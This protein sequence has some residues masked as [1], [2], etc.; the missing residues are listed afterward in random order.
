MVI[1]SSNI[2]LAS[3]P[4][5][6]RQ[7]VRFFNTSGDFCAPT[8][9]INYKKI[10]LYMGNNFLGTFARI[11]TLI[12]DENARL[13][14]HYDFFERRSVYLFRIRIFCYRPRHLSIIRQEPEKPGH[15][16]FSALVSGETCSLIHRSIRPHLCS[17]GHFSVRR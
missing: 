1:R 2:R 15:S 14:A 17:C 4:F 10:F 6:Y 9:P 5:P 13:Y 3:A 16:P 11:Q 8:Y 12:F 7:Y